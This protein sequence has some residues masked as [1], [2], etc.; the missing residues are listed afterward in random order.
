VGDSVEIV[1]EDA[2]L[3]TFESRGV[4]RER[5]V[6]NQAGPRTR[7]EWSTGTCAQKERT[8]LGPRQVT[9]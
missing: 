9:F 8:A 3:Q 5:L 2:Q 4:G 6:T 7:V 1:C